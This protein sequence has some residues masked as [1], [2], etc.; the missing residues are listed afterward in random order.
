MPAFKPH[1]HPAAA[2]AHSSAQK[3]SAL[4]TVSIH[5]PTARGALPV[6][7]HPRGTID[8][9]AKNCQGWGL[10]HRGSRKQRRAKGPSVGAAARV[11][12]PQIGAGA[13]RAAAVEFFSGDAAAVV[14]VT[15]SPKLPRVVLA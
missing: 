7:G 6:A 14:K 12:E 2:G 10:R 9:G 8:V 3:D 5:T 13:G 1:F 11:L 4:E 15:E